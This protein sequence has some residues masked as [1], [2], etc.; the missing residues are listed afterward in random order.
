V[1]A[2]GDRQHQGEREERLVRGTAAGREDTCGIYGESFRG[3]GRLERI[4]KVLAHVKDKLIEH[5]HYID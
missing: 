4:L 1:S 5:K 3:A 2:C